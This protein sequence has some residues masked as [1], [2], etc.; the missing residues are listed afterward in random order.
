MPPHFFFF[1]NLADNT[2]QFTR[3]KYLS[4]FFIWN[5]HFLCTISWCYLS[6]LGQDTSCE[7]TNTTR[8]VKDSILRTIPGAAVYIVTL[9]LSSICFSPSFL[10]CIGSVKE[11]DSHIRPY[12]YCEDCIAGCCILMCLKLY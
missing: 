8:T 10:S 7:K 6:Y 12:I 11:N 1:L 2:L 9:F 5:D 4:F 3:P